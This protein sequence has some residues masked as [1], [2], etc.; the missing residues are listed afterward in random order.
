MPFTPGT[1]LGS[2]EILALIGSGGMGEVFRARDTKLNRDVAVKVLPDQFAVDP[3]RLARFRR[4]AQILPALNHPNIG[5]IYGIEE[6]GGVP[7]IVMELV[8]GETLD[9][10]LKTRVP[11]DGAR[12]VSRALPL[13]EALSVARQIVD[14]LGAAHEQGIIHRDLKPANIKVRDDGTV[15]VLDFGLGK[16]A[17]PGGGAGPHTGSAALSLSPTMTSPA[18]TQ[19]GVILGTAAYMAPEQ[20]KGIPADKRSD[21]WAFGCV[22]YEM[23]THT[24]LRRPERHRHDGECAHGRTFLG[25]RAEHHPASRRRVAATVSAKR[26][27]PA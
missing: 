16:V 19:M 4:E 2:F 6:S 15:K 13:D 18:M 20:A 3:D 7:A 17:D 23:L 9:P 26:E 8:D 22:L 1:R 11:P 14:A 24:R 21:V 12:G 5:Q 27:A 25:S 10:R